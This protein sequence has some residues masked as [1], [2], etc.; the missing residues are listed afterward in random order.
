MAEPAP[1]TATTPAPPWERLDDEYA[2]PWEDPIVAE[3]RTA[4]AALLAD[5]GGTLEGLYR[6]LKEA[7]AHGA[8]AGAEYIQPPP[9]PDGT[10][11][12]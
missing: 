2:E 11:A 10:R 4:R 3:V 12:P 5:A 1:H 7:E 6:L 8:A 9:R